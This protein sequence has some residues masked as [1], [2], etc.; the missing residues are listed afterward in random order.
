MHYFWGRIYGQILKVHSVLANCV[1][2]ILMS[3]VFVKWKRK[4]VS[5]LIG[6]SVKKLVINVTNIWQ[7]YIFDKYGKYIY[8]QGYGLHQ[9]KKLHL[10]YNK[11]TSFILK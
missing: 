1:P 6:F 3:N 11:I 8:L 4:S 10:I 5:Y 9:R 2:R 7:I